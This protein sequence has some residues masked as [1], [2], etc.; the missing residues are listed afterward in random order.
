MSLIIDKEK[1]A[2]KIKE[3]L[4][5][6][7]Q[8]M[9]LLR[10]EG[11]K[12]PEAA[13]VVSPFW[14]LTIRVNDDPEKLKSLLAITEGFGDKSLV[15]SAGGAVAPL[16]GDTV[17]LKDGG[18]IG[19]DGVMD[20]FEELKLTDIGL[21]LPQLGAGQ[22]LLSGG[23]GDIKLETYHAAGSEPRVPEPEQG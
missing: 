16:V 3:I 10:T 9:R 15:F 11:Q 12:G 14:H 6:P 23:K 21:I 5:N 7:A 18:Q 4:A 8:R 2:A 13:A 17:L 1:L 20:A 19:P 22:G